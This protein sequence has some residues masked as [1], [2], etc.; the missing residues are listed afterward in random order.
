MLQRS[1]GPRDESD[2]P[3]HFAQFYEADPGRLVASLGSYV[4][5]GLA[6][7]D[8]ILLI[9]TA[10][11]TDALLHTLA[12][13]GDGPPRARSIVCL[14]AETTLRH[15]LVDGT[16]D[17]GR[18]EQTIG[19]AIKRVQRTSRT[20]QLRA[21]GE[22]VGLL[23]QAGNPQAA[24]ILERFW[25]ELLTQEDFTLF[26]GYPIDVFGGAFRLADVEVLLCAHSMIVPAG[27]TPTMEH[28]VER[29]MHEVL[30]PRAQRIH[31]QMEAATR[32]ALRGLPQPERRLL[33][34]REHLPDHADQIASLARTHYASLTVA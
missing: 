15:F 13:D 27:A 2:A 14:D 34:L 33:W 6:A 7:G 17:W 12:V 26:C 18:F 31:D 9:A 11:H 5:E 28:A 22:M 20:G 24:V 16:P 30:G 32:A 1:R 4:E 25:N 3:R 29:A 8:A 21:Y 10:E 23:W 19:G